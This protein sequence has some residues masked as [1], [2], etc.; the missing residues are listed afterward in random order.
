VCVDGWLVWLADWVAQAEGDDA[1]RLLGRRRG[2]VRCDNDGH[3]AMGGGATGAWSASFPR[4]RS[5]HFW[6][7]PS[8]VPAVL[9]WGHIVLFRL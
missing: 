5:V 4:R 9:R 2:V 7:I 3:D 1:A 8:I 6:H